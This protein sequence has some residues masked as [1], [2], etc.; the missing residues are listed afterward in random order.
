MSI[1]QMNGKSNFVKVFTLILIALSAL[2]LASGCGGGSGGSSSSTV[3][4]IG[5]IVSVIEGYVYAPS[6]GA[7]APQNQAPEVSN[8]LSTFENI[9]LTPV[10]APAASSSEISAAAK[11]AGA[12]Q[13]VSRA[14]I[15]PTSGYVPLVGATVQLGGTNKATVTNPIGYYRFE[16][17]QKE[18][19]AFG[20]KKLMINK[21]EANVSIEFD[22]EI[23]S[24]DSRYILTEINTKTGEKTVKETLT[25]RVQSPF[26]FVSG[27]AT[28]ATGVALA[29]A[30]V[31]AVKVSNTAFVKTAYTDAYG[32]Y[33]FSEINDGLYTLTVEKANYKTTSK[34]V[35]VSSNYTLSN[36]D[37]LIPGTFSLTPRIVNPELS[38]VK[39]VYATSVPTAYT[40]EYGLSTTYLY[41]STS[42]LYNL[43]NEITLTNLSPKTVYHFKIKAIDQ[44]GNTIN[45]DDATFETLDPNT[46][47]KEAP[48]VNSNYTIRKTHNSITLTFNTNM[49]SYAQIEYAIS[50]A[51][52]YT[53]YPVEGS[54]IGPQTNFEITLPNLV[55]STTYKLFIIT[56]NIANKSVFRREPQQLP[57]QVTT[58]N[59]PDLTPPVISGV[60][61]TGLKAKEATINFS[62]IDIHESI[63]N[64]TD[65]RVY[66]G[67]ASYPVLQYDQSV[68]PP[69]VR[70][71]Y[72]QKISET[73]AFN[74][75]SDKVIRLTG[76]E[77]SKK[78]YFR[79]ASNDPSGNIGTVTD[80]ISFT[81]AA[82]GT[83]LTFALSESPAA[84]QISVGEHA[85]IF[86]VIAKGS[87]E[88]NL[89]IKKMVFK[90]TGS[91]PYNAIDKLTVTDGVN[92]W[93]VTTPVSSNIEVKFDSPTL[94]IPKNNSMYL[95][96]NMTLNTSALNPGGAPRDVK[97]KLDVNSAT[98]TNVD[99]SGDIYDAYVKDK[100]SGLVLESSAQTINI[101]QLV[102][103]PPVETQ[104][105][106]STSLVN[107]GQKDIIL[108]KFKLESL[109]EDINITK[110]QLSQVGTAIAETDYSNIRLYDGI[111][112]LAVGASSGSDILFQSAT[113]LVKVAK[114]TTT[115]KTLSIVADIQQ[116]ATD[117]RYL[118]M[119][120]DKINIS[121]SGSY[122]A[123]NVDVLGVGTPVTGAK[124]TIGDSELLAARTTDSPTKQTFKIGDTNKTFT[125]LQ[126]TAGSAED[127][128][129]DTME[130]MFQG[131]ASFTSS[132]FSIV[133]ENNTVIYSKSVGGAGITAEAG[134]SAAT[135]KFTVVPQ[136]SLIVPK[137][138]SKKIYIKGNISST[139][140][141]VGKTIQINIAND[142]DILGTGVQTNSSKAAVGTAIGSEHSIIGGIAMTAVLP[143]PSNV[144]LPGS[145][146]NDTPN[147]NTFLKFK[148]TPSG[149]SVDV[150]S[151]NFSFSGSY[152]VLDNLR[153]IE[154]IDASTTVE[155]AINPVISGSTITLAPQST[156]NITTAG[157]TF[158]LV[159]DILTSAVSSDSIKF[160]ILQ[161]G[162]VV[163]GVS[164][165]QIYKTQEIINGNA[166]SVSTE[167]FYI[168]QSSRITP[169]TMLIGSASTQEV[170]SFKLEAKPR[171]GYYLQK[172]T[173]RQ[174]GTATFGLGQDFSAD[175]FEF[176]KSGDGAT[177]TKASAT[178]TVSGTNL[179]IEFPGSS[180]V[181]IDATAQTVSSQFLTCAVVC[182]TLKTAI[183]N[184]TLKF[185][186]D[187]SLTV[188]KS[189]TSNNQIT[190]GSSTSITGTA[191]TLK[192][193]ALTA[194]IRGDN[195]A[196]ANITD[197]L[198]MAYLSFDLAAEAEA[199]DVQ[200][201]MVTLDVKNG[202]ITDFN[203][204]SMK[205]SV[206]GVA[207]PN[208]TVSSSG[209]KFTI[210]PLDNAATP[211]YMQVPAN[212]SVKV[213]ISGMANYTAAQNGSQIALRIADNSDIMS[214][215]A[216]STHKIYSTGIIN[217]NYMT[218]SKSAS[219]LTVTLDASNPAGLVLTDTTAANMFIIKLAAG[220]SENIKLTK[221]N[222]TY[223]GLANNF[224]ASSISIIFG[225]PVSKTY[226]ST[227]IV[228]SNNIF[229]L[230]IPVSDTITIPS[231]GV[232]VTVNGK[233]SSAATSGQQ[234]FFRI[235]GDGDLI[236]TGVNSGLAVLS[237][238]TASGNKFTI[239]AA[240]TNIKA[241]LNAAFSSDNPGAATV[242]SGQR[243]LVGKID[244]QTK[245]DAATNFVDSARIKSIE[246][247]KGG[248]T[249]NT[250]VTKWE[251]TDGTSTFTV[252]DPATGAI[253]FDNMN[254]IVPLAST[255]TVT[256]MKTLS[257]YATVKD[258]VRNLT[259]LFTITSGK[260]LADGALYG[261][262]ATV[263]P[264]NTTPAT[265]LT[266]G[267][268]TLDAGKMVLADDAGINATPGSGSAG[269]V[270]VSVLG[271]NVSN[272]DGAGG[273]ADSP[274]D[275]YI[276]GLKLTNSGTGVLGTDVD[277]LKLYEKVGAVET[278]IANASLMT[279]T[280]T[281]Q[282]YFQFSDSQLY[283]I[284][285]NGGV[286]NLILKAN[287][288]ATATNGKTI[289]LSL[290]AADITGKG[291]NSNISIAATGVASITG[292]NIIIGTNSLTVAL[293]S[294]SP[295]ETN[296]PVDE[297]EREAAVF[298]VKTGTGEGITLDLSTKSFE[299]SGTIPQ[300][301]IATVKLKYNNT[302]YPLTAAG[303]I[304]TTATPIALS[305]NTT[306]L[307][308]ILVK[309]KPAATPLTLTAGQY[310]EFKIAGA[311][312][313]MLTGT[314]S[315]TTAAI[316][317]TNGTPA[318]TSNKF[319]AVGKLALASDDSG[320]APSGS[321]LIGDTNSGNGVDMFRF[322]LTPTS[323]NAKVDSIK[324]YL[325][326]GSFTTDID[327]AVAN[328]K[329]KYN[330]TGAVFVGG[331]VINT[332]AATKTISGNYL[333][334]SGL[335]TIAPFSGLVKDTVY[336]IGFAGNIKSTSVSGTAI[337]M[338]IESVSDI[339]ATGVLSSKSITPSGTSVSGNTLTT[340]SG[341]LSIA[342][343]K[344]VDTKEIIINDGSSKLAAVVKLTASNTEKLGITEIKINIDGDV[345]F[346]GDF[347]SGTPYGFKIIEMNADNV[348]ASNEVQMTSV[349]KSGNQITFT[350][351][352]SAVKS[353]FVNSNSTKN[354]VIEATPKSTATAGHKA[355]II[356]ESGWIKAAGVTSAKSITSTGNVNYSS[357]TMQEFING[358]LNA[359]V[360]SSSP[361][362]KTILKGQTN[363]E[364]AKFELKSANSAN[365]NQIEDIKISR[366]E[367]YTS[368]DTTNFTNTR[369]QVLANDASTYTMLRDGSLSSSS[370]HVFI[371]LS[372][373][374]S[375][376]VTLGKDNTVKTVTLISDAA[377]GATGKIYAKLIASGTR[378]TGV[379]SGKA[380]T[381]TSS[382][383]T[384]SEHTVGSAQMVLSSNSSIS[385]QTAY[386]D[387][388]SSSSSDK[389]VMGAN[390]N[391][392]DKEAVAFN[393]GSRN[394]Q[395]KL[396]GTVNKAAVTAL[397]IKA[398]S[399][400][401]SVWLNA[402][403]PFN[404]ASAV[405]NGDFADGGVAIA[406]FQ[407]SKSTLTQFK[408]FVT[409]DQ[410]LVADGDT[411]KITIINAG[412]V[413]AGAVSAQSTASQ[414]ELSN[415]ITLQKTSVAIS[416]NIYTAATYKRNDTA[417]TIIDFKMSAGRYQSVAVNKIYMTNDA[418]GTKTSFDIT[419]TTSATPEL[420]NFKLYVDGVLYS[421]AVT[422]S[423]S[424]DTSRIAL[425]FSSPVTIA[426][427]G[428]RSFKVAADFTSKA[429]NGSNI[430]AKTD[431]SYY[432]TTDFTPALAAT[433]NITGNAS[434]NEHAVQVIET[435][436]FTLDSASPSSSNITIT[437]VSHREDGTNNF[438]HIA[439]Y[440]LKCSEAATLASVKFKYA[441]SSISDVS[442]FEG[443]IG[444]SFST[445][446]EGT[447]FTSAVIDSANNKVIF[448]HAGITL[449]SG[450][451][452]YLKI[453]TRVPN[454]ASLPVIG[455]AVRLQTD[456]SNSSDPDYPPVV[457]SSPAKGSLAANVADIVY[458]ATT[459]GNSIYIDSPEVVVKA[460]CESLSDVSTQ[461]PTT[462]VIADHKIMEIS[463]A[464][465]SVSDYTINR[466]VI[467]IRQEGSQA[468]F[469]T[470]TSSMSLG[471]YEGSTKIADASVA[472][473]SSK[474]SGTFTINNFSS[475]YNT[476]LKGQS[477]KYS[478]KF[479]SGTF[480]GVSSAKVVFGIKY[481]L[482]THAT[483]G[484]SLKGT[485]YSRLPLSASR[486][487]AWSSS[488][489]SSVSTRSDNEVNA[490]ADFKTYIALPGPTIINLRRSITFTE[491]LTVSNG[492]KLINLN[493]YT[494][495]TGLW[496]FNIATNTTMKNGSFVV[497]GGGGTLTINSSVLY[498][499][500]SDCNSLWTAAPAINLAAGGT[501]VNNGTII[502]D[503]DIN[504]AGFVGTF[505]NNGTFT[506]NSADSISGTV[507]AGGGSVTF[508]GSS[509]VAV[510]TL[511]VDTP[512][513][514]LTL[515]VP[516]ASLEINQPV[517]TLTITKTITNMN[518]KAN[519][520][521]S[522][523]STL[524]VGT[525]CNISAG[526]T[527]INNGQITNSGTIN[528][529]GTLTHNNNSAIGGTV[530]SV[531]GDVV[532]NGT[533][534]GGISLL[535]V[536]GNANSLK[537]D[538]P[539]TA[540][541]DDLSAR[542][543]T[544]FTMGTNGSITTTNAIGA[545]LTLTNIDQSSVA[546]DK[547][548][549][550][551]DI[552][553]TVSS[554]K[555]H[556]SN[557]TTITGAALAGL[558]VT[559][560][561]VDLSGCAGT[562][563]I[564]ATAPAKVTATTKTLA[565]VSGA[566]TIE[567]NGATAA[568]VSGNV[569]ALTVSSASTVG[570][571]TISG[572]VTVTTLSINGT[573]TTL[574]AGG[575]AVVTT[576]TVGSA[577]AITTYNAS[578]NLTVTNIDQSAV[579]TDKTINLNN[580][581]AVTVS[582]VKGH[583]T[584]KLTLSSVNPL[585]SC[586]ITSGNVDVS[587]LLSG[588]IN[589]T[590]T[591]TT[592]VTATGKTLASVSGATT[593]E[594]AG[595]TAATVT[596]DVTALTVT[597]AT[598]VTTLTIGA[599]KTVGTLSINGVVTTLAAGGAGAA[600]TTL[601]I[602][603]AGSITNALATA[604]S[605][606]ITNIDQSAVAAVK[607][608]ALGNM[609][610]AISSVK[611]HS[612]S[613]LSLT[614]ASLAS[615]T[616][617]A[618]SVDVN[619][620][621]AAALNVS[622]V[623]ST[624]VVATGKVLNSVS[625]AT[626]IDI[627]GATAVTV[628]GI[629]TTL[630]LSG[631][632]T[633]SLTI[634]S[635][636]NTLSSSA[637]V[638]LTSLT[639]GTGG[640]I[641]NALATGGNL[642]ITGIDQSAVASAAAV[643]LGSLSTAIT[644]V[645]GHAANKLTLSSTGAL[646][647]TVV[648]GVVDISGCA[649][650]LNIAATAA[651]KVT[652]ST[653]TLAAVSGATTIDIAGASAATISGAVTTLNISDDVTSLTIGA[654][655]TTMNLSAAKTITTL[656]IDNTVTT[657]AAAG[658][659]AVITTMTLGAAG[660]IT[661]ALA[662]GANL[663]ITNVDQSA[664]A[665]IKT[666]AFG[667][668]TTA[669][670][671]VKGHSANKLT[672]T[673]TGYLSSCTITGGDVD[674]TGM[675]ETTFNVTA[676]SA[677]KVT[678]TGKTIASVSGAVTIEIAGATSATVSGAV[679][680][681]TVSAAVTTLTIGA[682]VTNS[683]IVTGTTVN[684]TA[685]GSLSKGAGTGIVL[686]DAN[687]ITMSSGGII[688]TTIV[689]RT[690]TATG[691]AVA[692]VTPTTS[693][694]DCT[695]GGT[696]TGNGAKIAKAAAAA[697]VTVTAL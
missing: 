103:S 594:I 16:I 324:F 247:T 540:F 222:L 429:Q 369:I 514:S 50:S 9:I 480:T 189:V 119:Q 186:L 105:S 306:A 171:S 4:D 476:I 273:A 229:T 29:N 508:N 44:Y 266:S 142:G 239:D 217:G 165:K 210:T 485:Q 215:G 207:Y 163:S 502:S 395:V 400:F 404:N 276:T 590:A 346:T 593:I 606:T 451:S 373:A 391:I 589:V 272:D 307:F 578:N 675:A 695:V 200:S 455:H 248:T 5:P 461:F 38:A 474:L 501:L 75:D 268:Q 206:G 585:T 11:A 317:S 493:G 25:N 602:G 383:Q 571:L 579:A 294:T 538:L 499:T 488:G 420:S 368:S 211:K 220:T 269:D 396:E 228:F 90:Q 216:T 563:N 178:I 569:T 464:N 230:D 95:T 316:N 458:N 640:S 159:G 338:K 344:T 313:S 23:V 349:T 467:D 587:G 498:T 259:L 293:D 459:I 572:F 20:S 367:I 299:Y 91:I 166:L 466:F 475:S 43:T 238:G 137:G 568:T 694:A 253:K 686:G 663:T 638:T 608:I 657:L 226:T 232:L 366:I 471:V 24:G 32:R 604:G 574:G 575:S 287:V 359:A 494:I 139:A 483:G 76:L 620:L 635:T 97:L 271:M 664:V 122:S 430:K 484:S 260:V 643:S 576:M 141:E 381:C 177:F 513:T 135:K 237:T 197:S 528:N 45:T 556:A 673:S 94:S 633:T 100:V 422:A 439:T 481:I 129:I 47:S 281:S 689:G 219:S 558:T 345:D 531:T 347:D 641:T 212:G 407:L 432:L 329:L 661:N 320:N 676:T 246:L 234:F 357:G 518:V 658:A 611:G 315:I 591:D 128:R 496:G 12:S 318:P 143:Q 182:K 112:S 309:L 31:T 176:L 1:K 487:F 364:L 637:G 392:D 617:T 332:A 551:N 116:G 674:I 613:T 690:A 291:Y 692:G 654:A 543:I 62:A 158:Y 37:F 479:S 529:S 360:S 553:T 596:G 55:N 56:K 120:I 60:T 154:Y 524:T 53:R 218:V 108:F 233:R 503:A 258:S 180:D 149:E 397:K 58:D 533:S 431:Y 147:N 418:S 87:T 82:P 652:A 146:Y 187:D 254:Y 449:I 6:S 678:A 152:S 223:D 560:G 547:T 156:V 548:I 607:T 443:Y 595:A 353:L 321:I 408:V 173:L 564:A 561:V 77:P 648:S 123:Q 566:T 235:S 33:S 104:D 468:P 106:T 426:A 10:K 550:L 204:T 350:L 221:L 203:S 535:Q 184:K 454:S 462:G 460:E 677:A 486:Y 416:A 89:V 319:I 662:T 136:S 448:S 385:P 148:I 403:N 615:C 341:G 659:G 409:L 519:T 126:L 51:A 362:A 111:S 411:M 114:G 283:K 619:A 456:S 614:G 241:Y 600:I 145:K 570:T 297:T 85:K 516:V 127:V 691:V 244:L 117:A 424:T 523:S 34:N 425:A 372:T 339:S 601:S 669:V 660:V 497:V 169:E 86:R 240:N 435:V 628:S 586:T 634:N 250:D 507:K 113:G 48:L 444:T 243:L 312:N 88:E 188:A 361:S 15:I 162:N 645:K 196:A 532:F 636:V 66:Y 492:P 428:S 81:T 352:S 500:E 522:N 323:E 510:P 298:Q 150:Q 68:I 588:A 653:K 651:T 414:N 190:G 384:A 490:L 388:T 603:S 477:K 227:N 22:V 354:I 74:F 565:A 2:S 302:E 542:V 527:F 405:Y 290:L 473:D 647:M 452:Y 534:S 552:S 63:R 138:S 285:K 255:S 185:Y 605:L 399:S 495:S 644:T 133:D 144:L 599:A 438:A 650:T 342:D 687:T 592:K 49:S 696:A 160:S 192:E 433:V 336:Y 598:T 688:S 262:A 242:A 208:S 27:K 536:G 140:F 559:Q 445:Y 406:N 380:I 577:G 279:D 549:D 168:I 195:P 295:A 65:A 289:K 201:I 478:V 304:Y 597:A 544:T 506:N 434:G 275:V 465:S 469:D 153:V 337:S 649:G 343:A 40:I 457:L 573:I 191:V 256:T 202:L 583:A 515:G 623:S 627:A 378:G 107:R 170:Y 267:T 517:N 288:P 622:A 179:S 639:I 679:T 42:N 526:V 413:G 335:S 209:N 132:A 264:W 511:T 80:E 630:N 525:S 231:A 109:Y 646:T 35:E 386:L 584:N 417:K 310:F 582:S 442:S 693:G 546:A 161:D 71:D 325:D 249:A 61:V 557:K 580:M 421:G 401:A 423:N 470:L 358:I 110:I 164:S 441:G 365:N 14:T 415:T 545:N 134:Y 581:N 286:K 26:I 282:K 125:I 530:K 328:L 314:S 118:R 667:S 236:G 491:A 274:E 213:T 130:L 629:V 393:A 668:M 311:G 609:S 79:P 18:I 642:T 70:L 296:I 672:L 616:I 567:I 340:T 124:F 8:P 489:I 265:V 99:V 612:T 263:E 539:V 330:N 562:L 102:L 59:S 28:G 509:A 419:N 379:I 665:A 375:N 427:G 193:G 472:Y 631:N 257:V 682:P 390:L 521:L 410:T 54:E 351:D 374:N 356:V 436:D 670:S 52:V 327:T 157:K 214:V 57:I 624:K 610:T 13:A 78:Y 7:T 183:N 681:L 175:D 251:L 387:V 554:V 402:L 174:L 412:M 398:G 504:G 326:K 301:D 450:T 684:V 46:N 30:L 389:L 308:S 224:D 618:G 440:K 172:L 348:T 300:I 671:S 151:F 680:T 17:G 666:I 278:F 626:T 277:S 67:L 363:V 155:V 537:I 93:T 101:G 377:S 199:L 21:S 194:K 656:N 131:T 331:D 446:A 270:N 39:I 505:I 3:E 292:K 625:G 41:S 453:G 371:P 305:N 382:D 167:A 92:T 36:I 72:Y 555:G 333:T 463:I 520:T 334:F 69:K 376:T 685:S 621:T 303:V 512:A 632:I 697:T 84:G 437:P 83:A 225:A 447:K 245:K 205:I 683:S 541:D 252:S 115:T 181:R 322:K 64:N 121:G 73:L 482:G 355:K 370:N 284:A 261:N 280:A 655:V 98:E 19:T 96:I 198:E 394:I